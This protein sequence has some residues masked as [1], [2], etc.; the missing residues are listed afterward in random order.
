M[1][2]LKIT[3]IQFRPADRKEANFLGFADIVIND[4]LAIRGIRL[5]LGQYGPFLGF[6]NRKGSD[7][8]YYDIVYP[9]S[10]EIRKEFVDAIVAE[11]GYNPS[12]SRQEPVKKDDE[13]EP[14]F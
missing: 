11:S 13:E 5:M 7:G 12:S 2:A 8:K 4:E 14:L 10:K 6:P 3:K 9:L 1:A